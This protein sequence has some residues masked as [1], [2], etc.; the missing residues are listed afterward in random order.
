MTSGL[1]A[2]LPTAVFP[3]PTTTHL[4][5]LSLNRACS[6]FTRDCLLTLMGLRQKCFYLHLITSPS[7]NLLPRGST[8]QGFG[9]ASHQGGQ[10]CGLGHWHWLK[11]FGSCPQ[12]A[13][14]VGPQAGTQP[15][16]S[17]TKPLQWVMTEWITIGSDLSIPL[18]TFT[19]HLYF[20]YQLCS[21]KTTTMHY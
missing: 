3:S 15:L 9:S 1:F 8:L 11:L 6:L 13:S 5:L 16:Q 7:G 20:H 2:C 4:L 21:P 12:S 19:K 18:Q 10:K 17:G 14:F